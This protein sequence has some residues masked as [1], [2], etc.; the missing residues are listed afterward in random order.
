MVVPAHAAREAARV[1]SVEEFT[2]AQTQQRAL[3]LLPSTVSFTVEV[4]PENDT[5]TD[6][7]VEISAPIDQVS[8]GDPL[9]IFG[10]ESLSVRVTMRR[11]G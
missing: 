6:R 8:A 3:S 5:G 9:N 11:E 7:F 4:S 10:D 2:A 1:Y